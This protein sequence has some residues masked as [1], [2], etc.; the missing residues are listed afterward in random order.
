MYYYQGNNGNSDLSRVPVGGRDTPGSSIQEEQLN[1]QARLLVSRFSNIG[2]DNPAKVYPLPRSLFYDAAKLDPDTKQAEKYG[3]FMFYSFGSGEGNAYVEQYYNSERPK[4]NR[5]ISS[6]RSKNPSAIS[7][8]EDTA[9]YSQLLGSA[10]TTLRDPSPIIGGVNAPYYWKDFIYCKYYGTIP[11]N[12][13]ITLRRFSSPVLD[14]FSGPKGTSTPEN[15]KKGVGMPVAQAVTW[16]GGNSGNSL[17]DLIG[18]S[19][20]LEWTSQDIDVERVQ[21]AFADGL[22]NS[23]AFETLTNLVAEF[24]SD[25]SEN[26]TRTSEFKLGAEVLANANSSIGEELKRA[27]YFKAFFDAAKTSPERFGI[28]SERI[29]V[30]VDVIKETS[31][32]DVGLSFTWNDMALKFSYD[33]T[34]AGEVNSK[35]AMFD[36]LGN[37]LSIGTNYGSF[38]APY[39]KYDSEYSALTFPGGDEG[40]KLAYTNLEQFVTQYATQMFLKSNS[41]EKGRVIGGGTLSDQELSEAPDAFRRIQQDLEDNGQISAENRATFEKYFRGLQSQLATQ[42]AEAWQ[43]P[44]SL[45]TGAPIGE[46]HLVIGNPYNPIAMMGNLIC[47]G[48]SVK[49]GNSLGPDDFPS[50]LEA[51]IILA[52]ARPRERGEIESIFNRGDG[53]L[54]QTVKS[55]SADAQS[56]GNVVDLAGNV[57]TNETL[58]TLWSDVSQAPVTN[59]DPSPPGQGFDVGGGAAGE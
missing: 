18:F 54:Y 22:L 3:L 6:A 21:K 9:S 41:P 48:V 35:A 40:A 47:K 52:H 15:I 25:G 19:T 56:Y 13:L 12:R 23:T 14:N 30:P 17:S 57:T 24:K 38:L 53:R 46:W 33:L 42:A 36:I 16:F 55:T 37:L 49:F 31:K 1:D 29:W 43:A 59:P 11:N 27:K 8:I 50:S 45:Y 20:G 51:E 28:M 32:R 4:Y 5:R 10:S 58:N 44:L 7:L 26:A 34:S 39:I 2:A